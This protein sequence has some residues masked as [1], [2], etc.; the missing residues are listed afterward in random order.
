MHCDGCFV[1]S[2]DGRAVG[3]GVVVVVGLSDGD[4]VGLCI[5]RI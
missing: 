2:L 1:G 3:S 5:Y 4:K